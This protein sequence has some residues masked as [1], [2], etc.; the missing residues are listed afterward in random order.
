MN[1][2]FDIKEMYD[3]KLKELNKDYYQKYLNYLKIFYEKEYKKD[4]YIKEF[5]DNKLVLIERNNPKKRIEIIPSKFIDINSLYIELKEL[6]S[7]IL[8]TI[9]N[10]IES[11][12]N[13]TEEQRNYFED[14]KHRYIICKKKIDDI[15]EINKE[16]YNQMQVL[17]TNKIDKS[18]KLAKYYQIRNEIYSTIKVFIKEELK[19][20]LIRYFKENKNRIPQLVIINKIAKE[21]N[22]PSDE[23]EKWFK[24]IENVYQYILIQ[25]ETNEIDKD[26][27]KKEKDFEELTKYMIIKKPVINE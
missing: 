4:K 23:I 20:K 10:L 7:L 5:I 21:N 6:A 8:F 24:W 2:N 12:N 17:I 22:I 15:D 1:N 13:I 14:L 3:F 11:N 27:E 19:N 25:K 26:I 18:N 16:Y 9:N